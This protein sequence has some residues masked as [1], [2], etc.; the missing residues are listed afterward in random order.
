[1]DKAKGK[2]KGMNETVGKDYEY[3]DETSFV[4]EDDSAMRFY[5]SQEEQEMAKLKESMSRSAT[6]KFYRL[7]G[8]MKTGNMLKRAVIYH[9]K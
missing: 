4:K 6:E 1:M 2:D 9:K 7:M 8:L 5:G 3:N